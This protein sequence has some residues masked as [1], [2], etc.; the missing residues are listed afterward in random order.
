M[1]NLILIALLAL[2]LP[3]SAQDIITQTN[4]TMTAMQPAIQAASEPSSKPKPKAPPSRSGAI[5][6]SSGTSQVGNFSSASNVG[7]SV[8]FIEK[9]PGR[10]DLGYIKLVNGQPEKPKPPRYTKEW[11]AVAEFADVLVFEDK[12]RRVVCYFYDGPNTAETSGGCVKL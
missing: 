12:V 6:F 3:V 5:G 8:T 11:I 9:V 4:T 1:K 7:Q 2:A 10:P